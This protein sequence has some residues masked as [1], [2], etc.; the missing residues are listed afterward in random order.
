MTTPGL[1]YIV[2]SCL[3]RRSD[4]IWITDAI[5]ESLS[6]EA[7]TERVMNERPDVIDMNCSTRKFLDAISTMR[8][9]CSWAQ[10]VRPKGACI[11][12]WA[13]SCIWHKG[14]QS[15]SAG[16]R[17]VALTSSLASSVVRSGAV[18]IA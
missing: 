15:P 5:Y 1:L 4:E 12:L 6:E 9:R 8:S 7:P 2:S 13:Q 16:L 11:C 10:L 14:V 17:T 3:E 18:K